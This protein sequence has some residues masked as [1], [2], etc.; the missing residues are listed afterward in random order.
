MALSER[1]AIILLKGIKV[2]LLCLGLALLA[3]MIHQ[4]GLENILREFKKLGFNSL[5]ILIPFFLVYLL[6]ALAW[7][8]TLGGY[9]GRVDFIHLFLTRMAG[10]AIN[11]ITPS[12]Y[13]GGEPVK[14]Y[15]L[16]KRGVP[17]VDGL[18]SVVT[19]KTV[20]VI[21]QILFV[22]LGIG[23]AFLYRPNNSMIIYGA[24][25]VVILVALA[26]SFLVFIQHRGMFMGALWLLES[27]R[28]PVGF[29]KRREQKL[30]ALDDTILAFYS[31]HRSGFMFTL[32]F[33]FFAWLVGSLEIYLVLHFLGFP[34]D[35]ATAITIEALTTVIRATVFFIP[36][37]L[38]AQEGGNI[39]LFSAFGFSPVTAL[40]FSIIRRMREVLW[41]SIGLL[42]LVRQEIS[43]IQYREGG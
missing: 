41:I 13:L 35:L 29:L 33:F 38:G 20:M 5:I 22:L 39:L 7:K 3:Y 4:I 23:L 34:I 11:Y 42:Y 2:F 21:A 25:L 16:Q 31:Q 14:A 30:K 28:L 1:G 32:L 26:V 6:D 12:A 37:G 8:M 36:S 17:M 15:L 24:I 27:I 10:E 43:V 40:T 9:G 19:A 18:A